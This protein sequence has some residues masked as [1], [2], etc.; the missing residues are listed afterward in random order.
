M[1]D[2][3][4]RLGFPVFAGLILSIA[5][6]LIIIF[7]KLPQSGETIEISQPSSLTTTAK[8][9]KVYVTGAVTRPGVYSLMGTS[10]VEDAV[11]A[12]GGMTAEANPVA[13]NLAARAL[14][15]MHV[16][17]PKMGEVPVVAGTDGG[18]QRV[19]INSASAV[20]LETLPG[21]GEVTAKR[22]V[23]YRSSNGPFKSIDELRDLKLVT[24][25][26]F[27]KIKDLIAL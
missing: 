1:A 7:L 16:H 18:A 14:D 26:T 5:I 3:L 12:A 9:I 21:I 20:Q 8:E 27:E 4:R 11:K 22:I 24:A 6:A 19:S 23:D 17:V 10:R 25:A 15:E 2:L 13:V